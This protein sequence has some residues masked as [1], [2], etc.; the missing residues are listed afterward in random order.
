MDPPLAA[1]TIN[2]LERA[3]VMRSN[4]SSEDY[5]ETILV[6]SREKPVVRSVDIADRLGY[7]KSSV[8][9]AMKHQREEGNITVSPEGYIYLTRS[10]LE[11]AEKIYER[12]V[13]FTNWL[14]RLGVDPVVASNDACRMEHFIS[15]ESFGAIKR[16]IAE[17]E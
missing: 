12:H 14:I 16:F 3:T 7:K 2:W 6:L 1:E 15:E 13:T 10:G 17:N 5:L 8:S 9:V 11:I 4:E